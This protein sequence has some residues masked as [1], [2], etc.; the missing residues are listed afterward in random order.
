MIPA[1]DY[2]EFIDA[3]YLHDYVEGGGAA[4][5]FVV[6]ADDSS[7]SAFVDGF[8]AEGRGVVSVPVPMDTD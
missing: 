2:L 7:A 6:P 1:N 3:E 5:K 4:V 8:G